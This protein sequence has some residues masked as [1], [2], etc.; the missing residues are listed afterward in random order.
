M[1][2]TPQIKLNREQKEMMYEIYGDPI[3]TYTRA[4]AI[5][6]GHLVD[7]TEKAKEAGF[8]VPA[9]LTRAAWADCVEWDERDS[10]RQTHQDKAGRLW[11]V[12]WMALVAAKRAPGRQSLAFQLY[13]VP[14]GGRSMRPR[15]TRL[16]CHIGSGDDGEPVVT[17]MMP[18]E[19]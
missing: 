14:R 6:D 10:R 2:N 4:Q 19:D 13:R 18:G 5:E 17:I 7:V 1:K 15:L 16:V 9:A 12:L 8:R 3:Y 11:D